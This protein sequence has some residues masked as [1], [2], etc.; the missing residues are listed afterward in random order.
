VK[1]ELTIHGLWPNYWDGYVGCCNPSSSIAN[2]P[3]NAADFAEEQAYLLSV[4][5]KNWV[6]PTQA[7][8]YDTLCQIYNHE[9]QKHGLCYASSGS[10]YISAAATYFKAALN[11]ANRLSAASTKIKKW[12][13]QAKPQTTV[14][15]IKA[16]YKK[17]V[18]VLCSAADAANGAN[19]LSVIRTCYAKP[20]SITAY[21]PTTQIDCP[22]VSA[23]STFSI[24]SNTTAVTLNAYVAP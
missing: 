10:D 9:F 6:D 17:D 5:G 2:D 16:L 11:T 7:S 12:A 15:A 4:M 8:T 22:S 23:T 3:Y 14:A 21:G 13:A 24:C 18:L 1:S 20:S 19:Q